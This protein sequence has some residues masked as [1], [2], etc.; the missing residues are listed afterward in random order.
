MSIDDREHGYIPASC[1]VS[2]NLVSDLLLSTAAYEA[3]RENVQ[4]YGHESPSK[5]PTLPQNRILKILLD[6][7]KERRDGVNPDYQNDD[8]IISAAGCHAVTP[9]SKS[10]LYCGTKKSNDSRVGILGW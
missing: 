8:P 4:V 1:A 6:S 5:I 7:A 3:F 2:K 9:D 10:G